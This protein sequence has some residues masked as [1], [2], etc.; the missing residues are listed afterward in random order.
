MMF[1]LMNYVWSSLS[2]YMRAGKS[3][4]FDIQIPII[5]ML[6][7]RLV[8]AHIHEDAYENFELCS[9]CVMPRMW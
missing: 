5:D 8:K 3:L 6:I 7:A 1:D 9:A 2:A 4:S